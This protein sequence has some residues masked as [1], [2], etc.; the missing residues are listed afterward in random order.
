MPEVK[1]TIQWAPLDQLTPH[2]RCNK[3]V[4]AAEQVSIRSI[5]T[6]YSLIMCC[7]IEFRQWDLAERCVL[8]CATPLESMFS[9]LPIR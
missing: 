5:S 4:Y 2:Y 3:S 7:A 9:N 8:L 6:S 1:E